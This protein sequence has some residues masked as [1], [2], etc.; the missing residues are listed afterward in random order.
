MLLKS[1]Y[2]ILLIFFTDRN[3]AS[4]RN[5]ELNKG[6]LLGFTENMFSLLHTSA[7]FLVVLFFFLTCPSSAV[8]R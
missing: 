4:M 1:S 5:L 3:G 2:S 7:F 6:M 8:P